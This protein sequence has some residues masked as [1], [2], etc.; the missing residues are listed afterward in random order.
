MTEP[1]AKDS[2]AP[3]LAGSAPS[4]TRVALALSGLRDA[5]SYKESQTSDASPVVSAI[6]ICLDGLFFPQPS[7]GQDPDRK[8]QDQQP[9]SDAKA[10]PTR[11]EAA[12]GAGAGNS[13]TPEKDR[14][15]LDSVLDTLLEPSGPGQSHASPRACESTSPWCLFSSE[16]PEDP[17]VAPTTQGVLSPLMSR[18]ESKAG[19]SS[20][21]ATSHK[22]LP[23]GLSPSR[24]LLTLTSGS[25]P[26][27]GAAVK[28]APQPAVVD[29]EEED[30]FE[31]EGSVGP[32][33]KG[34]SRPLGGTAAAGGAAATSPGVASGGVTLIPKEDSRFL[35][36][37]VSL[38]EQEALAAPGGS[39]L[40]T[41]MMDF[42]HVPILPLNSAFLA[43]R[44]RQLLEGENYDGGAAAVSTF[45]PP[46][47][48]PSGSSTQVAAGDFSDC[49]YPPDAEPKVDGFPL[50]GD[51][52]PPALKIKEEEEGTEAAAHS[53]RQYLV[54]G[55][56]PAVFPDLQLALQQL[57][58]R[59]PSSRPGEAAVTAAAPASVSVSSVSSS[60]ST[61]ECILYKAEGTPPQQDP[62]A[63]PPCKAPGAG[64]C[65]LPRDSASTSAS[66]IAA[67][68]APA[69]YPQLSLNGLPQ[70]GYQAAVLKE[71][72]PQVYQP[73]LNYL[74]PDSDASQSPQYSFESLPQK[75]CLIC[76][77]EASGCHYGVLTCG[78]CKVFFKRAME[79]QHNYLCAGR[80]D[81][82]VDKIRRK[83]CPACR[84]RKCC[85]AGMVLGGRKFKKF[86]KVRV[87]RALDAVALPQSVGIPNESQALSQ[88][89]SFS[90]TQDI[91]LI[92]PLINLL[93][94]IEPEVIYAGHDNTK[95]D[96]SSSLLT[97]LN[98]LGERQLL[99]VVKWSKSLPGFRNLHI[100]DQITLIQYSWMSLMVFGLGWRS[101]KHVSGQMLYFAPDLIL[102]EQR[103]KESSF[104]SLCLTMWQIP[105][106]FV[107]LQ[108]SQEEFLCMKVL[109]LLNTI[110]LEGLR[111]QNQFEEMRSSYIRELIKAIGLRQKGVVSSS[112][113][114]YQLTKLLD[115]LHDLVK[116]LHLYCLNTFIQSRALSVEF[117]EMM[118]EVIAAQLP[119]ILAGMVKPLLFHKK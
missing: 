74:R 79:G 4:P 53:Q 30:G 109:L 103:M 25:H 44:T 62:F 22:V 83:N 34:K 108:V 73:Y 12:S 23:R 15:L 80:N 119:K 38:T 37:K 19:D 7:Q 29:V 99:S 11:V 40:A 91:Q 21:T 102:N 5:G 86:N 43:A 113:R 90:P 115:N 93:M 112:Q 71:G 16:L 46:R 6:P 94:S 76:G 96:T 114:F 85:Q 9:L 60:G 116:Q 77:D 106:E 18:P 26:W 97:S 32:P 52:Q 64:A 98:Q 24:Q 75:I 50:Y 81:C 105:Q 110:P 107:K 61:L 117:P 111:S 82:I 55:P 100:D 39:P 78:S 17:R 68:V 57:P 101:Y 87:M 67:G 118:S 47:G 58:P 3:H 2:Q 92:P 56:N 104:Y 54:T 88:R 69:L 8:T 51:F 65:L 13:R 89:I 59:A 45:A 84:L 33:L 1:K 48:S 49:A 42:I 72:L 63:P 20:G 41:T 14:G 28:P 10:A 66:A 31:S 70:L 95:P 36:P 35:A 27:R